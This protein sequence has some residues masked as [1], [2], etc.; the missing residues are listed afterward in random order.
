MACYYNQRQTPALVFQPGD[1]VFLDA[2]DIQT[3]RLSRK[4]AHNCLGPY[5]VDKQVN[6]NAYR[7]RLPRSMS[8]LH[9]VF[10]VV[11][12]TPAPEDPIPTRH[13]S[14]LPDP[15][16]VDDQEEWEVECILDSRIH[17]R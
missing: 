5:I 7:L 3:T 13:S 9:P 14:L 16:I 4:L 6:S 15:I 2:S 17:C 8:H 1:K 12:L 10:N 11:K